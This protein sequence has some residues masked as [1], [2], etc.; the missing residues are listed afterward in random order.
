MLGKNTFFKL[1]L[2]NLAAVI[3]ILYIYQLNTNLW[4]TKQQLKISSAQEQ[5]AKENLEELETSLD[6]L[7]AKYQVGETTTAEAPKKEQKWKDGVYQGTGTG[8]SGTITME[9]TIEKGSIASIDLIDSGSDDDAYVTMAVAITDK[10]IEAQD[11][12]VDTV[13]GATFSSNGIKEGVAQALSLA[14]NP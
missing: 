4:E 8:F 12:D 5:Q 14:E 2:L 9:V 6:Q 10:M 1:K 3:L 13:S 7:V 11:W